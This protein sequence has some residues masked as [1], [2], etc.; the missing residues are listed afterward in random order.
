MRAAAMTTA[1]VWSHVGEMTIF[2][3]V[4]AVRPIMARRAAANC[5]RW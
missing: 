4:A 2:G 1:V 5:I 3:L